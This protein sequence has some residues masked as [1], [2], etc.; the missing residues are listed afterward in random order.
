MVISVGTDLQPS[1]EKE[2]SELCNQ[3][4]LGIGIGPETAEVDDAVTLQPVLM[5]GRVDNFMSPSAVKPCSCIEVLP[6]WELNLV[7]SRGVVGT[8]A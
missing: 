4:F 6:W 3:L 2:C 1:A 8:I 5:A 7:T